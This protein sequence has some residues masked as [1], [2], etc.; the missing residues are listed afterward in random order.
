MKNIEKIFKAFGDETRLKILILL[1]KKNI[2][3]KGLAKHLNISEA[4]VSQHIKILKET[5][6]IE[7]E[8]IGYFVHYSINEDILDELVNFINAIKG[9]TLDTK[10]YIDLPIF[11]CEGKKHCKKNCNSNSKGD[12]NN[13][14]LYSC[15]RK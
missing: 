5:N 15:K 10:N 4:A 9:K 3:A 1:S 12:I 11:K 13:E 2:C 14:N 8:K 7:G 6:I